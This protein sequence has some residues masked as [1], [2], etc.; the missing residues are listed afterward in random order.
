METD[1][2]ETKII[3]SNNSENDNEQKIVYKTVVRFDEKS[4]EKMT[5]QERPLEDKTTLIPHRS[6]S[7]IKEMMNNKFGYKEGNL[8]TT[9]DIISMY[10]RGQKILYLEAK[11]Y[12]EFYLY[13]LMMPAI[14]ISSLCSVISGIFNNNNYAAMAISGATAFNSF[15]LSIVNYLKLD[16]RAEAH[17]MT[18]YSFDQLICETEFT[19]GKILLSNAK[20][21]VEN[22]ENLVNNEDDKETKNTISPEK[23]DKAKIYDL[24]YVQKFLEDIEIKVKEIKEKNQFLIPETIRNRYPSIYNTNIFSIVK[25]IQIDEMIKINELKVISNEL[26]EYENKIIR[27]DRT[28]NN[29]Q[30]LKIK[31]LEKNKKIQ[32]ILDFRKNMIGIDT[33]FKNEI[34]CENK[35]KSKCCKL[36]Y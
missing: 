28:S 2:L 22:R 7:C 13:R 30:N 4:L 27:G 32:E 6:F 8:S 11:A 15:L 23:K 19:S 3:I 1:K 9:L 21:N 16:A 29:Y 20:Y 17:K 31:D 14:L 25:K 36:F 10:L 5:E 35:K 12:C 26:T 18:A 33:K 24:A 34:E